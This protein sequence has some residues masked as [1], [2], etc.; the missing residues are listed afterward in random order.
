LLHRAVLLATLAALAVLSFAEAQAPAA[1][2]RQVVQSTDTHGHSIALIAD[3]DEFWLRQ[4]DSSSLL[5]LPTGAWLN[6]IELLDGGWIAGGSRTVEGGQDLFLLHQ[7]ESLSPSG[8]L[9]G[10]RSA[11]IRQSVVPLVHDAELVGIAWLEGE[12]FDR[13]AVRAASR[14]ASGWGPVETVSPAAPGGQVAL[15][16]DV[17]SDGS[18]LLVW[19]RWDGEDTETVWSRRIE[20]G[21]WRAVEA[22]HE[23]NTVPDLTPA[24]LALDDRALVAWSWYDGSTLRQRLSRLEGDRWVDTGY[25]GP[26]ASVYPSFLASPTGARLLFQ[27]IV[28]RGWTIVQIDPTGR[29]GLSASVG[30]ASHTRP[31]IT[32]DDE[33]VR[34][35]WPATGAGAVSRELHADWE[36]DR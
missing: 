14:S 16:G 5:E 32:E 15:Q 28:P 21:R 30:E 19:S 8:D 13:L 22:V 1:S 20:P 18:W 7:Q 25:R 2:I 23:P 11:R 36:T 17:L 9:P 26:A 35:S 27:T 33:G 10:E 3:Q 29:Q 12:D 4:G 6:R 31:V 24:L 34:F